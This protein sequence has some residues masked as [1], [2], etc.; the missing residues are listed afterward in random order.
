M[1]EILDTGADCAVVDDIICWYKMDGVSAKVNFSTLRESDLI[2][3]R[4]TSLFFKLKSILL[5]RIRKIVWALLPDS[6]A[7]SLRSGYFK[8]AGFVTLDQRE[9]EKY[10]LT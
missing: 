7:Q 8:K 3:Q 2:T 4:K 10:N 1:A 6:V 9:I 5:Q